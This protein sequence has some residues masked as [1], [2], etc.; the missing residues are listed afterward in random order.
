M[1]K[2]LNE[3]FLA[4]DLENAHNAELQMAVETLHYK[5]KRSIKRSCY[6]LLKP[7]IKQNGLGFPLSGFLEVKTLQRSQH[8]I[9]PS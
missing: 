6:L 9:C 8:L 2:L 3:G 1:G 4:S 7:L 5:D